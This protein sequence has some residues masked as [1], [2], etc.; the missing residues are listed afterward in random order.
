M[1]PAAGEAVTTTSGRSTSPFPK[2]DLDS[3]RK[4]TN[5]LQRVQKWLIENAISEATARG[6]GFNRRGF[7][8]AAKSPSPADLDCAELYLFDAEF[9][10]PVSPQ[11][12]KPLG[13]QADAV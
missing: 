1:R 13:P 4:A 3:N 11:L 9:L 5:T 7:E 12:L 8:T 10:R 6:D 2:I